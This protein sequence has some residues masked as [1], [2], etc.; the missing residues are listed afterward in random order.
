MRGVPFKFR[1]K[2]IEDGRIVYGRHLLQFS[3]SGIWIGDEL[4]AFNY[5]VCPDTVAQLIGYDVDGTEI[6]DDDMLEDFTG[7]SYVVFLSTRVEG[8]LSKG[9]FEITPV[10]IKVQ[11]F[12]VVKKGE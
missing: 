9:D 8:V 4:S 5:Q 6:Y 1:G 7:D 10:D 12:K 3:G 2:S 11:K